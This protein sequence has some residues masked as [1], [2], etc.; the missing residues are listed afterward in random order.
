MWGRL[1]RVGRLS[2]VARQRRRPRLHTS[3]V[4]GKAGDMAHYFTREE[5]EALLPS[6]TVV[7]RTIQEN[8]QEIRALEAQLEELQQR[9]MDITCMSVFSSCKRRLLLRFRRCVPLSQSSRLLAVN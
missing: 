3:G 5:A 6:I 1:P 7:L 4:T 8:R 2:L 9:A